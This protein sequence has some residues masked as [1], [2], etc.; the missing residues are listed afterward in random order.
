MTEEPRHPSRREIVAL[1]MGAFVVAALPFVGRRRRLFRR[2][3]PAMG[4]VADVAVVHA[5]AR[6][7]GAAIDAALAELR[8]I[9]Q[10]MT[11]FAPTSDIGRLNAAGL[12]HP[13]AVS[14][15]TALVL[16][17][18]L[19]WAAAS[20]GEFDPCLG[21]VVK[22]WDVTHRRVPP[23]PSATARL[24]GR[25][26]YRA[27]DVERRPRSCVARLTDP[28]AAV[29]LGG[30]AKGYGVDRAVG[31]LR[32]WG[33]RDGL[34]SAGG[35]LYALGESA[36]GD[37]WRVGIRSPVDATRY[38]RAID[39]TD[40][41]VATSG[42]YCQYFDYRGR[43]YHHLLDPTTAAPHRSEYH[44]ITVL[45][46]TCMAA[47][48]AATAAFGMSRAEADALLR[49]HAADARLVELA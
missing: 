40:A 13:V 11:R 14:A 35:D 12:A 33:I 28:E 19:G 8:R 3:V 32:A 38:V 26:F 2:S 7:A 6:Y 44:S 18:A 1:A 49:R 25:R 20:D 36:R 31:V 43:R 41:A 17:A 39:L 16:E 37:L 15:D 48:A 46:P 23:P 22:L 4:T 45:A 34:V 24:A 42:D 21:R 30:I 47:D 29:D 10:L 9:E 27:L 5:D